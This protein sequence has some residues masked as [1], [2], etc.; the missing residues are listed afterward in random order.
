[1]SLNKCIHAFEVGMTTARPETNELVCE[2]MKYF[3]LSDQPAA[4]LTSPLK[5]CFSI[6]V[7]QLKKKVS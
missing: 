5:R 7:L 6:P 2:R 4:V 3:W 1:M